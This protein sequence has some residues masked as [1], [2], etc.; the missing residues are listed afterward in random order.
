MDL[1]A[2]ERAGPVVKASRDKAVAAWVA[3][4]DAA[5][6]AAGDAAWVAARER[7]APTVAALQAS[8]IE[9]YRQMIT[10]SAR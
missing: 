7:L 8:A 5:G 4:G 1:A 6:V 2:A 9:L 3:A 10:V